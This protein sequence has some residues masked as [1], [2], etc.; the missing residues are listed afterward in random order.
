MQEQTLWAWF[1]KFIRL[2]DAED[3]GMSFCRSCGKAHYW[4]DLQAGHYISRGKKATKY[5]ERNVFSQCVRC[6]M[7]LNG[8]QSGLWN[9]IVNELGKDVPDELMSKSLM[10]SKKMDQW[11]IK[12]LSDEYREKVKKLAKEKGI[13]L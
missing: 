10:K 11:T 12:T 9:W 6:N 13:E 7:Y 3:G 2:R 1:S 5:D 8:N 4:K